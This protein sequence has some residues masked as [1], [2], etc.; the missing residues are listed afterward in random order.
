QPR[1]ELHEGRLAAAGRADDGDELAI[2]RLEVDVLHGEFI[3]GLERFAI[4]QPDTLEVYECI[5]GSGRWG[6]RVDQ[7]VLPCTAREVIY[8][9]KMFRSALAGRKLESKIRAGSR[10]SF[11]PNASLTWEAIRA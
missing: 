8:L 3:A 6:L 10:R 2:A 5:V 7:R 1:R 11:S 9:A 4:G